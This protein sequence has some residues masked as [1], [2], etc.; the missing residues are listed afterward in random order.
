MMTAVGRG[1]GSLPPRVES[2][3]SRSE[4]A[5]TGRVTHEQHDD[6]YGGEHGKANGLCNQIGMANTRTLVSMP[7]AA[8]VAAAVH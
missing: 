8:L 6:G 2:P 7:A 5:S 1:D 4:V 3:R